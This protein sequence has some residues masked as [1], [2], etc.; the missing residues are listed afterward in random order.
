LRF[1]FDSDEA[2]R[3]AKILGCAY[4]SHSAF[5]VTT[6]VVELHNVLRYFLIVFYFVLSL[7]IALEVR[8]SLRVIERNEVFAG[9]Q[10]ILDHFRDS[11]HLKKRMLKQH[12][13]ISFAYCTGILMCLTLLQLS[14]RNSLYAQ[15]L[16]IGSE[17]YNT[18]SL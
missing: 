1:Y 18:K 13:Y 7:F 2:T 17:E 4:L 6:D 10:V 12:G 11:F 14:P 16:V 9:E 15:S 3:T 8:H 5:F